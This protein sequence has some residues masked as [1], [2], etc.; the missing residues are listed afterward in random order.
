MKAEPLKASWFGACAHYVSLCVVRYSPNVLKLEFKANCANSLSVRNGLLKY[1]LPLVY[2][3]IG[4][5]TAKKNRPMDIPQENIIVIHVSV[6][7][8]GFSP[9]FPSLMLPWLIKVQDVICN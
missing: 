8:S 4:D 9:S 7:Y 2:S 6:L 3:L 1:L 5:P